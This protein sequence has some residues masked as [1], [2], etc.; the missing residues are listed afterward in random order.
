LTL[1]VFALIRNR[2]L[3]PIIARNDV[4]RIHTA[5][6]WVTVIIRTL[7]VVVALLDWCA[8]AL[9]IFADVIVGAL[10]CVVAGFDIVDE[11]APLR[12]VA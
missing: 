5:C 8:G 11:L 7:V 9:S 6:L 10:A 1:S 12:L 4:G 2:T 3:I